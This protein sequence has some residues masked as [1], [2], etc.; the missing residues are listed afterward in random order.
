MQKALFWTELLRVIIFCLNGVIMFCLKNLPFPANI[1][2]FIHILS[3]YSVYIS[4]C[5]SARNCYICMNPVCTIDETSKCHL[6]ILIRPY[7]S[8]AG[9]FLSQDVDMKFERRPFVDHWSMNIL[10]TKQ[11]RPAVD[12]MVVAQACPVFVECRRVHCLEICRDKADTFLSA[13]SIRNALQSVFANIF[14]HIL[15]VAPYPGIQR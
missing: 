3:D 1:L 9:S 13:L 12:I 15:V 10:G 4:V 7:S 2:C 5:H 8:L 6:L 11:T 14:F